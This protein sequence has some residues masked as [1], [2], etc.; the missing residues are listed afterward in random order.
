MHLKGLLKVADDEDDDDDPGLRENGDNEKPFPGVV[1][2]VDR[3]SGHVKVVALDFDF[4]PS[5]SSRSGYGVRGD[6]ATRS[7]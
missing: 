4:Q 2:A 7:L 3:R 6:P 5:S 1:D